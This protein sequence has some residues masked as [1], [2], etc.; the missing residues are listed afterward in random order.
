MSLSFPNKL[1]NEPGEQSRCVIPGCGRPTM[2]AQG[3]GLAVFHCRKCV[4]RRQR[5]GSYWHGTYRA[6]EIAPYLKAAT[7]YIRPRMETDPE[8]KTAIARLNALLESSPYEIATRLRGL[9]AK[10]RA[11]IAFGRLHKAGIRGERLLEI[12]LAVTALIEEDPNSPRGVSEFRQVQCA[13]LAHRRASGFHRVWTDLQDRKGRVVRI[14]LH[15][16]PR[17]A[18]RV[19]RVMGKA[20]EDLSEWATA[21]HM[22]GVLALKI[23]RYG[24]ALALVPPPPPSPPPSKIQG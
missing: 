18:G 16:F 19:L 8:I 7:S 4:E 11:D 22:A 10:T 23:R 14:E 9:P 15:K 12:H 5:H 3:T 21:K 13:K 20:I 2:R 17:S 1:L 24:P 6:S